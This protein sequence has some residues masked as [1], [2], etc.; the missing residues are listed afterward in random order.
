[1]RAIGTNGHIRRTNEGVS[2]GTGANIRQLCDWRL[3]CDDDE[4]G[5]ET[6]GYFNSLAGVI[7]KGELIFCTLDMDATP[8][9]KIYIVTANT[10]T[11]VTVA[12]LDVT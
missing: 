5:V 4:A 10:G 6:A 11:A 9:G 8:I 2:Y 12:E 3:V 1:M 7:Q